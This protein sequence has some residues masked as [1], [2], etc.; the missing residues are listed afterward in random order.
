MGYSTYNSAVNNEKK[1][2]LSFVRILYQH[3]LLIIT[4]SIII[5]PYDKQQVNQW[6]YIIITV[7]NKTVLMMILAVTHET[8]YKKKLV[9][10]CY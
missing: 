4:I 6:E 10:I 7:C 2:N 1:N 9:R 3:L 8:L 5:K